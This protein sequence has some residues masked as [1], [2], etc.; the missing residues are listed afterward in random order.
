MLTVAMKRVALAE[1]LRANIDV[2][3]F[4][5]NRLVR[6]GL[7]RALNKQSDMKVR[8]SSP[9]FTL[10]ELKFSVRAMPHVV[11]FNSDVFTVYGPPMIEET[12]KTLPGAKILMVGMDAD[13]EIFLRV[14]RVGA[15]GYLLKDA[16]AQ[17]IAAAVRR[18]AKDE[19]ICSPMLLTV[20]FQYVA[21]QCQQLP[22]F[23]GKLQFG[24]TGREQQLV[25]MM[26]RGLR[27]KEIA[28]E[29]NLSD[30]TV[31]HHVHHVL[32]KLG[33][34]GRLAA[35]EVCRLHGMLMQ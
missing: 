15:A 20:L 5:G 28:N 22:G 13:K 9:L 23:Y 19:A 31:K 21:Q 35:V 32:R 8:E 12:R 2:L 33:V 29:L 6:E 24:L 7:T 25:S 14:V 27:N 3:L 4:A 26:G 30:Q 18:V 16:S 34:S 11:I 1:R 17:E 10:E